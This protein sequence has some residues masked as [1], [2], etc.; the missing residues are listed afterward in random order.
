MS[1]ANART[2][3]LLL[4]LTAPRSDSSARAATPTDISWIAQ[5][6]DEEVAQLLGRL[7]EAGTSLAT[8]DKSLAVVF[9]QLSLRTFRQR[10]SQLS[11][12]TLESIGRLYRQ[13]GASGGARCYLLQMLANA[14]RAPALALFAELIVEDP[15]ADR[16]GV[17]LAMGPLFQHR[18]YDPRVL[19][20]HLVAGICHPS[21]AAAILDLCNYL[22]REQRVEQHPALSRKTELV[23]LL[24]ALVQR[25]AQFEEAPAVEDASLASLA[26]QVDDSVALTVALCD[27]LG[28]MGDV[29]AT[30]KLRQALQLKHRRLRTEAAGALARL[31][32]EEGRDTLLRLAAEPICRLRVLHYAE[33]LG[34][35]ENVE[36]KFRTLVARAEAELALWLAEPTQM[37]IPPARLELVDERLLYWPGFNDPVA[38]Y[39][40]R[41]LYP[42][43]K[44][45]YSNI[46]IAGPLT[47]A[48]SADLEDLPPNDIYAAFAGW[49]AKHEEIYE[50]AITEL[51]ER[52]RIEASRLERRLRDEGYSPIRPLQLTYFLGTRMLVAEAQREDRAGI[53]LADSQE[54][55]WYPASGRPRPIGPHEATCIYKGRKLLRAFNE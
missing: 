8:S 20:P 27:A 46:G 49:H 11:D 45:T 21:L 28:L 50:V 47:H 34:L 29:A 15:P 3:E 54:I 39:L 19:F 1:E 9:R 14:Q 37:G 44:G 42:F 30:G 23:K 55:L 18:M 52:E 12:R 33:E 7:A 38:C 35:L 32:D 53:G 48:F 40:F 43:R 51:D 25:L 36:P 6:N 2:A 31:G 4:T 10:D 5:A 24:G 26:K 22:T 17:G 41:F 16:N 13:L